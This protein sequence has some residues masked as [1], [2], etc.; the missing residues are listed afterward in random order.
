LDKFLHKSIRVFAFELIN[1]ESTIYSL[2]KKSLNALNEILFS[3]FFI[4]NLK[5]AAVCFFS[6]ILNLLSSDEEVM[7]Q[8]LVDVESQAVNHLC[9]RLIN[10]LCGIYALKTTS[11][12]G[13]YSTMW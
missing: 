10:L 6:Q 12:S 8:Q 7:A 3:A 13:G 9:D 5:N 2:I 4:G 11:F 1:T